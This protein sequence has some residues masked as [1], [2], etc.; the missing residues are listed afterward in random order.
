MSKTAIQY[1]IDQLQAKLRYIAKF[2]LWDRYDT[3]Y[4]ETRL[5]K[6]RAELEA[7]KI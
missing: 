7:F 3:L 5:S 6:L 4:L 1:E 2:D